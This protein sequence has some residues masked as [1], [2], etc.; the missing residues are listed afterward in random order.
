MGDKAKYCIGIDFGGTNVR[1]CLLDTQ[2]RLEGVLQLATASSPQDIVSQMV[3]GAQKLMADHGLGKQDIAGVGIG[4]PGPLDL[5]EGVI[6]GTPNIPGMED[7]PLRD[8]VAEGLDLPAT[9]END[10]NAAAY[11]EY[12]CGA[13]ADSQNMV[14]LTLGTGIGSGIVMDGRIL[15]GSHGIGAEIGHMIVEPGGE[16]CG[17]GQ[18]GCLELYCSAGHIARKAKELIE[19]D[20][21]QGLLAAV[22]NQTGQIT[23]KDIQEAV[24][25]DDEL[26]CE[27][28]D[29][30]AKYLAI[31]CVNICRIFDPD[32]IVLAGGMTNA[33][34]HL[35]TPLMAHF[36]KLHWSLTDIVTKIDIAA[37]AKDAGVIGAAGVAWQAFGPE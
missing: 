33:G 7:L 19:Q 11:G 30:A 4:S 36:E 32:Q 26:A 24:V 29:G 9:L 20:G 13:G 37:L 14:L 8:L 22:F 2:W 23:A 1:F 31:A 27:L 10:A 15:H 25:A 6:Y 12:L 17:C 3:C 18:Q 28:W 16:Q 21:Q 5:A 34:E 35:T